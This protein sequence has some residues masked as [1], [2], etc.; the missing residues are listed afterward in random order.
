MNRHLADY[1]REQRL[2]QCLTLQAL[3]RTVAPDNARKVAG[4]IGLFEVNGTIGEDLLAAVADA[5]GIGLPTVEALLERDH[6]D[7]SVNVHR[8]ERRKR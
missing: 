6:L 7:T 4:R 8:H 5:L 1:F 2:R 3:A